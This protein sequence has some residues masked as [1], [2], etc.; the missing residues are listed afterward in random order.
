[1]PTLTGAPAQ[2]RQGLSAE[3]IT[4]DTMGILHSNPPPAF[5]GVGG[6]H[7]GGK[8]GLVPR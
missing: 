7:K 2:D 6:R 3:V 1:M 5:A 8:K 4:E